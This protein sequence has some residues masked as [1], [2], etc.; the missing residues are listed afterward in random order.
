MVKIEAAEQVKKHKSK[1]LGLKQITQKKYNI[2]PGLSPK[3]KA[4]FGDLVD[5][6][7]MLVWGHSGQGKTNFLMD[8]LKELMPHG[9]VLY[10]SLEEGFE[11][12]MHSLVMR[13]LNVEEHGSHIIFADHTCTYD[14]LMH[15]LA[16]K[17]SPKFIVVDSIQY[18]AITYEQYKALK[19]RFKNK[20]FI[21]ISHAKGQHPDGT[22]AVKIRYDAPIKVHVEGYL[23]QIICRFGGNK[24]YVIWEDGA[25]RYYGKKFKS[26][27]QL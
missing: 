20:T 26:K 18:W 4:S 25:K 9:K 10:V 17:K 7:I 19:E 2:L 13:H 14:V 8:L 11:K 15:M 6:F 1:V 16:K 24:P 22:T 23:A 3:I 12:S 27:A 5:T 21:F